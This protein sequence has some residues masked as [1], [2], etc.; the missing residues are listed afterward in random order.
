MRTWFLRTL[1][2][3][4]CLFALHTT[5]VAQGLRKLSGTVF[6]EE[7][8]SFMQA[9]REKLENFDDSMSRG[10]IEIPLKIHVVRKSDASGT[11]TIPEVLDAIRH[12]NAQ[13]LPI[14]IRFVALDDY[15]YINN[16]ALHNFTKEQE[17][18]LGKYDVN[19]VIN[20][21]IVGTIKQDKA[22]Y[23]AYTY[24]PGNRNRDRIFIA[25]KCF[26]DNVSLVRQM[27]HYLGLYPTH[28]TDDEKR[29][30]ETVDGKNCK[31]AG[32]EIC[33]TPADPRLDGRAVDGRCE[34][35]GQGQDAQ[36]KFYR[37]MIE[38]FMSDNPRLAC[39]N[40]FSRQQYARMLYTAL[41]IR[42]YLEF[43]KNPNAQKQ[44]K[45]LEKEYG[46][47]G[48]VAMLVGNLI[49][50]AELDGNIYKILATYA[51]GLEYK[52]N[53][54]NSKK[55][56]IYVL[57]GDSLRGVQLLYPKAGDKVYF[58]DKKV[59][60]SVPS[61]GKILQMDDAS[62]GSN[63]LC[64]LFSKKQLPIADMI[65]KMNEIEDSRL[66]LMQRFYKL[67]SNDIVAIKD[68]QYS[69]AATKVTGITSDEY[70]VPIFIE[71][72]QE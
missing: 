1:V 21:Y 34:Y 53:I 56:Y 12:L 70:I 57:E 13:F 40:K 47:D 26:I 7:Q 8:K 25:Q 20:I 60:F 45:A 6:N 22:S 32:D 50:P 41:N 10:I 42:N 62:M 66:S 39:V 17:N 46:I 48:E 65:K 15:N 59:T 3:T 38:N 4:S 16:D 14:Y 36:S 29:S 52:L 68:L 54:T 69:N 63:Y 44:Q 64:V 35:I 67:Q 72:Y 43:P 58:E 55:C 71:Y 27:G 23:C 49:P 31:D 37:P 9:H 18:E 51:G 24:P 33:D 2:A 11:V 28:G 30:E 5:L 61:S 19:K